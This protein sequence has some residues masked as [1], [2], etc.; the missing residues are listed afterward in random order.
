MFAMNTRRRYGEHHNIW[1]NDETTLWL[2]LVKLLNLVLFVTSIVQAY[3]QV[4]VYFSIYVAYVF[5]ICSVPDS[6]RFALLLSDPILLSLTFF[7]GLPWRRAMI[8]LLAMV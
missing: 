1:R 8:S 7:C 6:I 3:F 2:L 5:M 4:Q